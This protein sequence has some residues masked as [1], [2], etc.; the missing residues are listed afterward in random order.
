M[1]ALAGLHH[2]TALAVDPQANLDFYTRVLGLRLVKLTVNFDSPDVYHLYYGSHAG[3]PGT[4]LTF[5]PFLDAARGRTGVGVTDAVSFAIPPASVD[6]WIGR[7]ADAGCDFDG[8]EE[9]FGAAVLRFRDPDGLQLELQAA[10]P[11]PAVDVEASSVAAGDALR[12]F[13]GVT[14]RVEEPARTLALLSD[15]FGYEPAGEAADRWRF[16]VPGHAPARCIDVLREPGAERHRPGG[17]TVHHIAFRVPDEA[18]QLDMR[19]RL[20]GLGFNVTEVRDRQY[21]KSIYFREPGGVLFELAT[22][23]PGFSA[24]EPVDKLGTGLKLPPWLEKD[25]AHIER[26]LPPVRLPGAAA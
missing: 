7:L 23:R 20:L 21:F 2:V 11:L 15:V 5:F 24:D 12:G 16:V 25:R 8:P 4:V 14:L 17:G 19:E 10:D 13:H 6:A 22:D 1:G 3:A 9:R 18:A 26:R